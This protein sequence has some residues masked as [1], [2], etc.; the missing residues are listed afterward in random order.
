MKENKGFLL[1]LVICTFICISIL[2]AL[3]YNFVVILING[4]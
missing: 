2:I 3:M 1:A 4:L